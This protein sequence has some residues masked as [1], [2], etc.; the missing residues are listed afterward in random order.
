MT[1]APSRRA[2]AAPAVD[3]EAPGES[4]PVPRHDLCPKR[5]LRQ[6]LAERRQ[7]PESQVLGLER[8][9]AEL[10]EPEGDGL[11]TQSRHLGA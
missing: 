2:I 3:R 8:L 10:P 4:V 7:G 1:V 6:S 11:R 5:P 9:L